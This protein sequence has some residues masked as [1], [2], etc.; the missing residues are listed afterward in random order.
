METVFQHSIT[1]E[2]KEAIGVYFPNE[3]AYLRVLGKETALFHLA[4]L[5]N[6]RNDIEKAEFYANQ[7]PEQ[8]KLDCLRTMHHP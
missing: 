1:Q 4:F 5:Y 8:D 7:L 2:E 3:V 6:H